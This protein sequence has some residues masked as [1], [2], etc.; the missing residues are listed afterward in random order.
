MAE[1][2]RELIKILHS[3]W[4]NDYNVL[5]DSYIMVRSEHVNVK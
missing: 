5:G 2:I 1:A 4:R 3:V